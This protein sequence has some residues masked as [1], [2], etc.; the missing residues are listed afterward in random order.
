M[1]M[2]RRRFLQYGAAGGTALFLPWGTRTPTA[3]AAVGG[4]LAKYVQP[5]PRVGAGIAVA[6]QTP[7]GSNSYAFTQ[8]EISRQLHPDLPATPIWAYDDGHNGLDGQAGS[9]GMAV[10]AQSGTPVEM[11][12]TNN[13]PSVYPDWIPVDPRLTPFRNPDGSPQVRVMTHLHGGFVAGGS[14]GNP[15]ATPQLFQRGQTQSVRYTNQLPQMPASLLWFHDHG[16]GTTRLNVFAGLAAAYV[17]R[18]GFDT[19]GADNVNGLPY[20]LGPGGFEVPLVIQDRQFNADGTFLYPTSDIPDATW[21]GEYFGDV[22]LVNGKVWPFLEVEPRLYR[23]RILNGCNARIM[24]LGIGGTKMWQIGAEGGLWDISVPVSQLVLAPAERADVL[25]DFSRLAGQTTVMTNGPLPAPVSNPAPSLPPVM[26]FRVASTTPVTPTIPTTLRGGRRADLPNPVRSRFITLN[27]VG[28]DTSDW[29]LT[30]SDNPFMDNLPPTETP[31]VGTVEDWYYINLTEDTHPM[32]THL[33]TFQVVRRFPF[34]DDAYVAA[35]GTGPNGGVPGGT[36]PTPFRTGPDLP[37][38]PTERGF[39]D[40]VKANPG[41]VTVIRARFDLPAKVKPPQSYV[42]H[43][44]IVEHEDN[45][46]MVPFVV[47]K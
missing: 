15:A 23:L 14:D 39:K 17:L 10:A 40:T 31:T 38:D 26:Q 27:E 7:S 30:L 28:A 47:S 21:I 12:F 45:D 11:T 42:H 13:L 34:D 18:D 29:R 43:C 44:H 32:H 3:T 22:M 4:K 6:Q 25:V 19:G 33:V 16:L 5:V 37:P 46:M 9:F 41:Q 20:G 1:A 2:T 8:T 24:N 36:D 35:V